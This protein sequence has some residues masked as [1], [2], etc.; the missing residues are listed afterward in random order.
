MWKRWFG[1]NNVR[2]ST[3]HLARVVEFPVN[4]KQ[5]SEHT[6]VLW[7]SVSISR[8]QFEEHYIQTIRN[9]GTYMQ[10]PDALSEVLRKASEAVRGTMLLKLPYNRSREEGGKYEQ[11]WKYTMFC[12]HMLQGA[13]ALSRRFYDCEGKR[14]LVMPNSREGR[15]VYYDDGGDNA[16]YLLAH[17]VS[18]LLPDCSVE[19]LLRDRERGMVEVSR[20]AMGLDCFIDRAPSAHGT[21]YSDSQPVVKKESAQITPLPRKEGNGDRPKKPSTVKIDEDKEIAQVKV[22]K[23]STNVKKKAPNKLPKSVVT[24]SDKGEASS[25][26]AVVDKPVSK[27][28]P[29]PTP[30]TTPKVKPISKKS[31]T[32]DA[33][34]M[35]DGM[36]K[37]EGVP[38]L[39]IF[40]NW[41]KAQQLPIDPESGKKYIDSPEGIDRFLTEKKSECSA[42]IY[43]AKL[44]THGFMSAKITVRNGERSVILIPETTNV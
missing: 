3:E 27:Q 8:S 40:R 28:K 4:K 17:N 22:S 32:A 15:V 37:V 13:G 38:P 34:G 41:I 11:M 12:C 31:N 42:I 44:K 24:R 5:I 19:W 21:G 25:L 14:V 6:T 33:L 7:S 29:T 39:K 10:D 9:V 30:T 16:R 23:K 18:A 2:F 43:I 35:S 26:V 36:T 1:G 20:A